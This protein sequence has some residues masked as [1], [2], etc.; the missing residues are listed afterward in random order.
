MD[1]PSVVVATFFWYLFAGTFVVSPSSAQETFDLYFTET[2]LAPGDGDTLP[3]T[4]L[5]DCDTTKCGISFSFSFQ[6]DCVFVS[7]GT[8]EK[9]TTGA[10]TRFCKRKYNDDQCTQQKEG[11]FLG[12]SDTDTC[13][14]SSSVRYQI[15]SDYCIKASEGPAGPYTV[16]MVKKEF[17]TTQAGCQDPNQ[18][19]DNGVFYTP[20]DLGLCFPSPFV[21]QNG[22]YTVG[23]FASYCQGT[24]AVVEYDYTDKTCQVEAI[25]DRYSL[26]SCTPSRLIPDLYV[27]ASCTPEWYCKDFA[28]ALEAVSRQAAAP[29]S[30]PSSAP[31]TGTTSSTNATLAYRMLSVVSMLALFL[32]V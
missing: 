20:D 3:G 25:S 29:T 21:E 6:D 17:Y 27:K 24:T 31:I 10:Q 32:G 1:R 15:L 8:Y 23:S 18:K 9:H 19:P 11:T 2:F 28:N 5:D 26:G 7:N 30:P 14:L 13:D 16:A 12:C 22:K 4:C